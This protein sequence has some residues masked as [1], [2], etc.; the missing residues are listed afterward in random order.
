MAEYAEGYERD[1][2][3]QDEVIDEWK[4]FK[5]GKTAG[6]K[7]AGSW[8]IFYND[9]FRGSGTGFEDFKKALISVSN[10]QGWNSE[11]KEPEFAEE[12]KLK[13]YPVF[14]LYKFAKP[15][16]L[17]RCK[18][19]AYAYCDDSKTYGKSAIMSPRKF[20]FANM[21][22]RIGDFFEGVKGPVVQT[23]AGEGDITEE[24]MVDWFM[25]GDRL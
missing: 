23:W 4:P 19:L 11:T 5:Q 18:F 15:D 25:N 13:A 2:Q 8:M 10:G 21:K 3:D 16:N 24:S 17:E 1:K 7:A 22:N 6:L 14:G 9:A 12:D 20:E